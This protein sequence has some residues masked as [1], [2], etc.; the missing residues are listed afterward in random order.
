M[1]QAHTD[2]TAQALGEAD[3][4]LQVES[5]A[6]R[7]LKKVIGLDQRW[8]RLAI[9]RLVDIQAIG[10]RSGALRVLLAVAVVLVFQADQ[11]LVLPA[12]KLELAMQL[13]LGNVVVP[14]EIALPVEPADGGTD[15]PRWF[16]AVALE[17][18]LGVVIGQAQLPAVVEVV[19]QG[20]VEGLVVVANAP[21]VGLA[22]KGRTAD[23]AQLIVD[24]R[25]TTVEHRLGARELG[26]DRQQGLGA[27]LPAQR[28]ADDAPLTADVITEAAVI[29]H[30]HVHPRQ[31]PAV[32]TQR[33]IHV[34]AAAVAVPTA[35][36]GLEL[37]KGF[38]L[39]ALGDDVHQPTRIAAPI[40]TGRRALEHF[41]AFDVGGIRGA[42][43][44]AIDGKA[45]LVQLA[46]GK[47]AHAVVEEGQATKVVLPADTAGKVQGAVDAR[48]VQILEHLAGHHGNALRGVADVSVRF[49][50]G[51]RAA[52]AIALHRPGRSFFVMA[53]VDVEGIEYYGVGGNGW[54]GEQRGG[55]TQG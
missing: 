43:A 39:R 19:F 27:Q 34:Q 48:A 23:R 31:H 55:Q 47:A 46:G 33:R 3:L 13:S 45:V 4:V 30:R 12:G 18:A 35:G 41:D 24:R 26:V 7:A 49:G 38:G 42:V 8:L 32:F 22:Q 25:D 51:A 28:R 2:Q 11:A 52:C 40:Q 37:G 14:L 21:V 29:L 44:T 16:R 9:H 1:L 6:L 17:P 50:R 36:A 53:L 5:V 10:Q 20:Q 15:H 54:Q